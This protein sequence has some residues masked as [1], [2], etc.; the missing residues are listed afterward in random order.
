[1]GAK[2]MVV[3]WDGGAARPNVFIS[4]GNSPLSRWQDGSYLGRRTRIFEGY[5]AFLIKGGGRPSSFALR[6][7]EKKS[8][9]GRVR[10]GGPLM[11][12]L[13]APHDRGGV[14]E[15]VAACSAPEPFLIQLE[16]GR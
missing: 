9:K 7:S 6:D 3:G 10:V 13:T 2:S 12:T 8:R 1:M 14:K 4:G 15:K 11:M 5:V 16:V